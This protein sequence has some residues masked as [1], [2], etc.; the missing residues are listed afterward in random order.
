MSQSPDGW[1]GLAEVWLTRRS[2]VLWRR[3]S[4][5][6]NARLAGA[7]LPE[8]MGRMLK[9][10]LF[11][12]AV[13][14][15]I[16]PVLAERADEVVGIDVSQAVVE[17]A[18]AQNE[19]LLTQRADVRE[20]PFRDESF[21][22]VLSNSTLDH[23]GSLDEIVAGLRE[24]HR[25]LRPG[26]T[27]VVTLDNPW[28]P[29]MALSKAVP[30]TWLNETWDRY[31]PGLGK[32]GIL[33]YHV[34]VT[35]NA[36]ALERTLAGIGFTV[37]ETTAVMHAPRLPAVLLGSVLERRAGRATQELFLELLMRCESLRERRTR[38]VTGT[39]VAVRAVRAQE[40][41]CASSND[42][43]AVSSTQ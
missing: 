23:F 1:D 31:A 34:G 22:A 17:A 7:W 4:D 33:P 27:L 39:F 43:P 14:G 16:L 6:V 15:G 38:L 18:S 5:A 13:S 25:V 24:L 20:L 26:G 35:M 10:D 19:Q 28:N 8:R 3:H 30:R 42:G 12:E 11:D 29:L 37:E 32:V 2:Q 9:T 36:P 41:P 40:R 21:D